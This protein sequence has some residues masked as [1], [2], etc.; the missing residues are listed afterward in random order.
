[1]DKS[2]E[3]KTKTDF[4]CNVCE[5]DRVNER[6]ESLQSYAHTHTNTHVHIDIVK[7]RFESLSMD[8][9]VAVPIQIQC[10]N[11]DQIKAIPFETES[12]NKPNRFP[13]LIK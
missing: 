7:C 10:L 1:M 9:A 3:T 11:I 5:A 2:K 6:N 4:I 13:V 8:V 12:L